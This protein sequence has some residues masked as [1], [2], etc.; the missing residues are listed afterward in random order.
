MTAYRINR[1]LFVASGAGVLGLAVYNTIT[2]CSSS[3]TP[4]DAAPT[5]NAP[6]TAASAAE[7]AAA[8]GWKRITLGFV[9]AYV[10]VRGKEAAVVDTGTPGSG[11]SIH[12]GLQAAGT[13]WG[14][15]KH[16]LITHY[17]QDHA[18][19]VDDLVPKVKGT[20]YAGAGDAGNIV[21]DA[22]IKPLNEGDDVFGLRIVNTPGH[23][24]GHISIL[25]TSTGTLIAGDALRTQNGLQGSDPQFTA[26]EAAAV[27]SVKKLAGLDI[28]AILPG[29]GEPLTSGAKEAL[30]K[31]AASL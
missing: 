11:E 17:H 14:S 10:L 1:R 23:T 24:A 31:L 26:D 13:D 22:D 8:T 21:S 28:K 9:S 5:G 15:V 27:A 29:H 7:S 19:G 6:A 3:S 12:T 18:G 30:Q 25:D 2:G 4:S 20:F 16:V